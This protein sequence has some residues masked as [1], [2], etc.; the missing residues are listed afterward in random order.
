[1]ILAG[2][3]PTTA[4]SSSSGRLLSMKTRRGLGRLAFGLL[5]AL[6]VMATLSSPASGQE[7]PAAA[8]SPP[9]A[10][11]NEPNPADTAFMM[12]SAA[13]VL[14]MTP[15]LGLFYGGMVRR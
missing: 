8:T 3:G 11:A 12:L 4:T 2:G 13:L 6:T 14:L 1:M 15:G 9:A 10:A 7:S 5:I